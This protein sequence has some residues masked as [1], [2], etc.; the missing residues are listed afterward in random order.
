MRDEVRPWLVPVGA[1]VA[2]GI[3]SILADGVIPSRF[4][5]IV[6]NL[7]SPWGLVAFFVGRRSD[8][9]L[10][11]ALG[12]A[13]A[14][15]VGVV[16]YYLI[17]SVRGYPLGGTV[18]AWLAASL[19]IGPVMGGSG[20]VSAGRWPS[21]QRPAAAA[22][23]AMLLAEAIF[24]VV[25]RRVWRYDLTAEP[26]RLADV[27]IVVL[28]LAGVLGLP[29]LLLRERSRLWSLYAGIVAVGAIGG[30]IYVSLDDLVRGLR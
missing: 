11:G 10:P 6:G 2:L 20:A 18:V 27:A 19:V 4:T 16:V 25:S 8:R 9:P 26:H 24:F 30:W 5:D 13:L 17:G 29:I 21:V 7:A 28:L 3:G 12:G 23:A 14:L 22:P 15:L 1:G